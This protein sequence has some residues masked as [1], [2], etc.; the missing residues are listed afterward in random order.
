ML[1]F[2]DPFLRIFGPKA[3]HTINVFQSIQQFLTVTVLILGQATLLSQIAQFKICF[4]ACMI[5]IM[6]VGMLTGAIR[7]LQRLGWLCNL[8]VW[9]NV[10]SFIIML[11]CVSDP[12]TAQESL[13]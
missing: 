13:N 1:S 10:A 4:A 7:S 3:R 8:S 11:V 5:I 6:V 2:G 9:L 12:Q